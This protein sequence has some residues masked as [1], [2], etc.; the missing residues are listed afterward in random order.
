M[1]S[2]FCTRLHVWTLTRGEWSCRVASFAAF[3]QVRRSRPWSGVTA[4]LCLVGHWSS[5]PLRGDSTSLFSCTEVT[6]HLQA[7]VLIVRFGVGLWAAVNNLLLPKTDC[8]CLLFAL[9]LFICLA[10]R[11]ISALHARSPVCSLSL[12]IFQPFPRGLCLHA[13][14]KASIWNAEIRSWA[15]CF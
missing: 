2:V 1:Q 6:S 7:H 11:S 9:L 3:P 13:L 5:P 10:S 15:I 14:N 12:Y 4:V 8:L